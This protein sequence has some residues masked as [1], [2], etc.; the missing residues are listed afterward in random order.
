MS[1]E[2]EIPEPLARDVFVTKHKLGVRDV[3]NY[4]QP[5]TGFI[6]DSK[7][8]VFCLERENHCWFK[9]LTRYGVGFMWHWDVFERLEPCSTHETVVI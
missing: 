1:D 6:L 2:S 5:S 3:P 8:I 7:D 9:V 4:G